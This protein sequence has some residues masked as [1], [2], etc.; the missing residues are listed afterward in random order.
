MLAFTTLR[1]IVRSAPLSREQAKDPKWQ[2]E[3]ACWFFLEKARER[4]ESLDAETQADYAE[5]RAY[6]LEDFANLSEKTRSIITLMFSKI[7]QPFCMQPLRKPGRHWTPLSENPKIRSMARPA[8]SACKHKNF[9]W[10]ASLQPP[11]SGSTP[12]RLA[13][14]RR[15]PAPKGQYLRPVCISALT[16]PSRIS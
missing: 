7:V 12:A 2:A 13:I 10:S 11:S 16:K 9:G 8:S 4:C 15:K 1:D 14:M 6:W 5:C 3:S